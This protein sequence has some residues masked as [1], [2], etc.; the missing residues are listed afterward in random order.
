MMEDGR[1]DLVDLRCGE[2][3]MNLNVEISTIEI[4][5]IRPEQ[6]SSSASRRGVASETSCVGKDSSQHRSKTKRSP[7]TYFSSGLLSSRRHQMSRCRQSLPQQPSV[8]VVS[9]QGLVSHGQQPCP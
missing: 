6:V 2:I 3:K 8:A 1:S 9:L 5:E 4:E 7:A